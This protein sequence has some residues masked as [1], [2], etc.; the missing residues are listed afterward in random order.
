MTNWTVTFFEAFE[1]EFDDYPEIVQDSI[2]A[3]A[4]LLER[5]GPQ[6]GR[7]YADTLGGSKHANMKELRCNVEDGVWRIAFAFDPK[8]KAVL[9]VAGDKSGVSERRFYRQ[10]IA[11]AD[12]RFDL[13]LGKMKG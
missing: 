13:H 6:L 1:A 12:E 2:L 3:R 5:V 11:R 7:P 10:L 4:D 9:L 8:R